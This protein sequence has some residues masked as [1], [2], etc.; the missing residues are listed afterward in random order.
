MGPCDGLKVGVV[1]GQ[2]VGLPDGL[3]VVLAVGLSIG[4]AVGLPVGLTDGF[5]VVG[6]KVGTSEGLDVRYSMAIF[7]GLPLGELERGVGS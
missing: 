4:F 7:A 1:D 3:V 5:T 6:P 2:K